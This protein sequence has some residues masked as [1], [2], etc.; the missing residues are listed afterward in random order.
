MDNEKQFIL[1]IRPNRRIS[2]IDRLGN[3]GLGC[4]IYISGNQDFQ[5]TSRLTPMSRSPIWRLSA[6]AAIPLCLILLQDCVH[7]KRAKYDPCARAS[8]GNV[9]G[10]GQVVVSCYILGIPFRAQIVDANTSLPVPTAAVINCLNV[11]GEPASDGPVAAFSA[12]DGNLN[13]VVETFIHTATPYFNECFRSTFQGILIEIRKDGYAA[14]RGYI[15]LPT[16]DGEE[17]DLGV[18]QLVPQLE[19]AK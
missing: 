13:G 1:M 9:T 14:F 12:D 16:A 10:S 5:A 17:V 7:N 2:P 18:I 19:G 8:R 4:G 15:P 3:S 11:L 6:L